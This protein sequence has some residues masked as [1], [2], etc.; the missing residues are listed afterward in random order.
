MMRA[1]GMFFIERHVTYRIIP[2]R[3]PT[4]GRAS[5]L[6]LGSRGAMPIRRAAG[7]VVRNGAWFMHPKYLTGRAPIPQNSMGGRCFVE[8]ARTPRRAVQPK[9][10]GL[11][12]SSSRI[13]PPSRSP[14]SPVHYYR[15]FDQRPTS[16]SDQSEI[17]NPDRYRSLCVD[18]SRPYYL[19]GAGRR[20]RRSSTGVDPT[21][22]PT[23][24]ERSS[25]AA[26]PIL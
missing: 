3:S 12:T 26:A 14:V 6:S 1:V 8:R 2:D 19:K 22:G 16:S 20:E 10:V 25:S 23:R 24:I 18:P 15:V 7:G 9:A 21:P 17:A 4:T 5:R 13:S 11:M